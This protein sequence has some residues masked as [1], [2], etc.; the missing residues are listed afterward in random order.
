MA[1]GSA[2]LA[3]LQGVAE[4]QPPLGVGVEHLDRLAVAEREHV[5]GPGGVAAASCCRSSG[6]YAE[7]PAPW[8]HGAHG[9]E[10]RR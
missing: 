9:G 1:S 7:H 5:A 4:D 8:R 2:S 6:M 10:E 3:R